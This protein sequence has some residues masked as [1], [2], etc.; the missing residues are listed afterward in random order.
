MRRA[1]VAPVL[2][3]VPFIVTAAVVVLS[4]KSAG[5]HDA[6][7]GTWR[8][9]RRQL[10]KDAD[11]WRRRLDALPVAPTGDPIAR[12]TQQL[13]DPLLAAPVGSY[14]G[15]DLALIRTAM[16]DLLET[17][18]TLSFTVNPASVTVLDDL[19]R[20]RIYK[21][22]NQ[23]EKRQ[24]SATEFDVRTHWS[25]QSLV[26]ELSAWGFTMS[27]IYLPKEDGHGMLVSITIKKPKFDPKIDEIVRAYEKVPPK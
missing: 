16:R 10:P 23:K 8:I 1:S 3:A 15:M 7:V 21:T 27:E 14:S 17:A 6:L 4:A 12:A 5:P 22:D 24:L 11:V 25:G 26:Q 19:E 13:N 9:D 2:A 18:E 20:A